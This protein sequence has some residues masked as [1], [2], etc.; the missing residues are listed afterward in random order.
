M[1]KTVYLMLAVSALLLSACSAT[2]N[3]LKPQPYMDAKTFPPLKSPAG[4]DV[5]A[6]DP[7][8]QIPDVA[9]GPV[10]TYDEAPTGIDPEDPAARCLTTPPAMTSS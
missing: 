3:C 4:L 9:S 5:P 10:G 6:P 1:K 8:L 7:N 2:P